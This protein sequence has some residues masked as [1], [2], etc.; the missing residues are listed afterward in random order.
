[1]N[2]V[3]TFWAIVPPFVTIALGL[4]TKKVNLSL[5]VGILLG[6]FLYVSFIPMEAITTTI[7]VFLT[8]VSGNLGVIVFVVLLGIFV[9][10]LN[11]SGASKSYGDWARTMSSVRRIWRKRRRLPA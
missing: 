11:L 7:N 3:A 6:A 10:L 2:T 9:Y 8:K 5:I 1:M 4:Y